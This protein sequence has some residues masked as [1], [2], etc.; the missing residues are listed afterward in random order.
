[1]GP[2]VQL[3]A[4]EVQAELDNNAQGLL[5]YVSRWVGQGVGCSKVPDLVGTQL[6][7]DRA[8]LRISSQHLANWLK[9]SDVSRRGPRN[10]FIRTQLSC[11]E[12]MFVAALLLTFVLQSRP[13]LISFLPI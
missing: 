4:A 3:S 9:H 13:L 11:A 2:D 8:T 12:V 1:M 6:M 7:E 5:G 10:S